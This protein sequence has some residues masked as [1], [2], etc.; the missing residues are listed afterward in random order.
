MT[1]TRNLQNP[2]KTQQRPELTGDVVESVYQMA[3]QFVPAERDATELART[4]LLQAMLLSKSDTG[5]KASRFLLF[6]LM[7]EIALGSKDGRP[8]INV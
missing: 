1:I 5:S 8:R 7:R 6:K 2:A 4:T 3:R